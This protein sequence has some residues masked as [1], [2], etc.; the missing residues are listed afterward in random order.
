MH[1]AT[2]WQVNATG[3]LSDACTS[4]RLPG[5]AIINFKSLQFN[6]NVTLA[7]SQRSDIVQPAITT[8]PNAALS[9]TKWR[10]YVSWSGTKIRPATSG[11]PPPPKNPVRFKITSNQK[12]KGTFSMLFMRIHMTIATPLPQPL[13]KSGTVPH[14]HEFLVMTCLV[15]MLFDLSTGSMYAQ[16]VS[17][18]G[19]SPSLGLTI[20]D[21]KGLWVMLLHNIGNFAV[22]LC[23]A[24]MCR[25][26]IYWG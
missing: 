16:G 15:I 1:A 17:T 20:R 4:V 23:A 5:R 11:N 9:S 21:A 13:C 12:K 7:I 14:H 26:Q 18:D 24:T 19:T 22:M 8:S 10:L 2:T 6:Q 3:L 25:G